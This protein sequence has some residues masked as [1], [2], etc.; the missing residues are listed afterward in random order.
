[1][2][3]N[4]QVGTERQGSPTFESRK[5]YDIVCPTTFFQSRN[6]NRRH[7]FDSVA[8]NV[9]DLMKSNS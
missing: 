7:M 4:Q 3:G 1:M 6:E 2:H 8:F 5:G 9:A